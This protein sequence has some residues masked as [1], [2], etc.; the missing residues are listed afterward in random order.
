M[1]ARMGHGRKSGPAN[2]LGRY[3]PDMTAAPEE[4]LE[5]LTHAIAPRGRILTAFS[6]GVDSTVVAAAARRVLGKANAPA[7][8]GDSASLPRHELDAARALARDLDLEL[9]EVRP[10]EQTDPGY[11]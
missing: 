11:Q 10:G 7:A 8:I 2:R 5:R 3:N 9:L 6:G 1:L 4:L